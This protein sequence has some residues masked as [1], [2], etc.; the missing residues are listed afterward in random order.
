M[1]S[2]RDLQRSALAGGTEAERQDVLGKLAGYKVAA[3]EIRQW[4]DWHPLVDLAQI[5]P[6]HP[7]EALIAKYRE[8][9]PLA[10]SFDYARGGVE[11]LDAQATF[12]RYRLAALEALRTELT[13]KAD[14][15][16]LGKR[17]KW[18]VPPE[19]FWKLPA[20]EIRKRGGR[21]VKLERW[22]AY[23][24]R[25]CSLYEF[26]ASR[27]PPQRPQ[28]VGRRTV[29]DPSQLRP[30]RYNHRALA[31]TAEVMNIFVGLTSRL[32][33]ASDVKSRVAARR[34]TRA[35]RQ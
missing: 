17:R 4:T 34:R 24:D 32:V 19:E 11:G 8:A 12:L 15:L 26:L 25:M 20:A 13:R 10:E 28:Q 35:T 27:V 30:T 14:A 16:G 29:L 31:L 18:D 2:K 3:D 9:L 33:K 5:R 6:L 1:L 22:E 7:L 21:Y 23:G